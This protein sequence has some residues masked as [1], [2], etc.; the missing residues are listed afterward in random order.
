MRRSS[1]SSLQR[2]CLLLVLCVSCALAAKKHTNKRG[3]V[4][5]LTKRAL[6][7]NG[8]QYLEDLS[9]YQME[10]G[11]CVRVKV[12]DDGD[13]EGNSY[14]YNGK[15][16]AQ[17]Q[18]F[19]SVYLCENEYSSSENVCG[20]CDKTQEYVTDLATYLET[21]LEYAALMCQ[22]CSAKCQN[23][24]QQKR[25]QRQL[26]EDEQEEEE[27]VEYINVDCNHCVDICANM[28]FNYMDN[29]ND[30]Q[31]NNN[32]GGDAAYGDETQ[33]LECQ[34]AFQ[35]EDGIQIYAG[36]QCNSEGDIKIG[37]YYD[38]ECT[39]K[40]S[41]ATM[42]FGFEYGTFSGIQTMCLS[43]NPYGDGANDDVCQEL[44]QDSTH[45]SNGRNLAG[46]DDEDEMPICKTLL[47]A[48]KEKTYGHRKRN[49][50]VVEI[51]VA[52]V[53]AVGFLWGFLTL[54]YTYF[55]R[56]RANKDKRE[57]LTD[58]DYSEPEVVVTQNNVPAVS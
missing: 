4:S 46:G 9:S 51:I 45:C 21:S 38:D 54:S 58:N 13:D 52:V 2:L 17:Y 1:S 44:Y 55:L 53:V 32:N 40:S 18:Q 34:E 33:Y 26:D 12:P 37:F 36:P 49:R 28:N 39:V 43:C 48:Y 50:R 41:S 8:Y 25:K 15:Y 11:K 27:E 6:E 57:P 5:P 23:R 31:D 24:R 47:K 19:A 35:D 56:H 30:N 42:D 10:F 16:Y 7:D 29:D 22:S 14:F 20:V 3:A